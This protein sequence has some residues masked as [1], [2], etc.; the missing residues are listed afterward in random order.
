MKAAM[1]E[2]A[3]INPG[4]A[5]RLPNFQPQDVT[6]TETHTNI[7]VNQKLLPSDFAH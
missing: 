7:V 5:A 2:A 6:S 3:K 1:D 4:L